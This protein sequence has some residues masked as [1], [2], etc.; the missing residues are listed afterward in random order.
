MRFV[1]IWG[2]LALATIYWLKNEWTLT[3]G[4]AICIPVGV[5][6][7]L[8]WTTL[9]RRTWN[10]ELRRKGLSTEDEVWSVTEFPHK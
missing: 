1:L 2:G 9:E 5:A 6:L 4:L 10:H 7:L 8:I 3:H